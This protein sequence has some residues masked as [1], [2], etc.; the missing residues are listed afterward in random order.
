MYEED[1][2]PVRAAEAYEEAIRDENVDLSTYLD[3]AAIYFECND[4]GFSA[5]HHLTD[6]YVDDAYTRFFELMA[7]AE[8]KYGPQSEVKFWVLYFKHI[9]LGDELK[10]SKVKEI[11]D[12]NQSLVPFFF[13]YHSEADAEKYRPNA[14]KLYEAVKQG[15][16]TRQRYIKSILEEKLSM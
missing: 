2:N 9:H 7:I 3:L 1:E 16:T 6:E 14:Q 10:T 13:L 5:Y 8:E 4:S 11:V 12:E 15:K